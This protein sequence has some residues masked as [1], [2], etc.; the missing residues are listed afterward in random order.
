MRNEKDKYIEE[1]EDMVM[2][3]MSEGLI[4]P[5]CVKLKNNE[6]LFK[7]ISD[8]EF[9]P[10]VGRP[11]KNCDKI[12]ERIALQLKAYKDIIERFSKFERLPIS[13]TVQQ[14]IFEKATILK[15]YAIKYGYNEEALALL[16]VLK[17]EKLVGDLSVASVGKDIL[18]VIT[19]YGK[20]TILENGDGFKGNVDQIIVDVVGGR[21]GKD[22]KDALPIKKMES[23]YANTTVQKGDVVFK[24]DGSHQ[25]KSDG[26][27]V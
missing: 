21:Y 13:D 12:K 16:R 20:R 22:T 27:R 15:D 17:N 25:W 6:K 9:A 7:F 11:N 19:N 23:A 24:I 10:A 3:Q 2:E 8:R 14:A 18:A 1:L 26:G 5:L 4:A